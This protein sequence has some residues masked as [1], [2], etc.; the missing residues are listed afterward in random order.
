MNTNPK[1]KRILCFGDSN[2]RGMIPV[3]G[4]FYP[5]ALSW[6]GQVQNML[7]DKFEIIAEGLYGRTIIVKEVGKPF[8]TGITHLEAIL[9]SHIPLDLLIIMLG[10]NDVKGRHHLNA[11]QISGHLN[12]FIVKAREILEDPKFNILIICP[13]AVVVPKSGI[14]AERMIP[15][16]ETFKKLPK[17]YEKVAKA[18]NCFYINAGDYV[19]VFETDGFHMDE[20]AHK[21]LATVVVRMI[22]KQFK[23]LDK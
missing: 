17:L 5:V 19:S 22:Q 20:M 6:P 15:G 14:L 11:I 2:T 10:T 21:K 3:V 18:N 4:G 12:Q 23:P 7:G 1:A 8:K 13:P 16:P 9:K